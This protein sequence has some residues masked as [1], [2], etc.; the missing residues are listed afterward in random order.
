MKTMRRYAEAWR[1]PWKGSLEFLGNII[2]ALLLV[3]LCLLAGLGLLHVAHGAE[4][5]LPW[6]VS[7]SSVD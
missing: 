4:L 5:N 3:A 1:N 2:A 6:S 7:R